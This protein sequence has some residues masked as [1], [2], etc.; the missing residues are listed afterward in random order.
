MAYLKRL[1]LKI[2]AIIAAFQGVGWLFKFDHIVQDWAASDPLLTLL[3]LVSFGVVDYI[4]WDSDRTRKLLD[5]QKKLQGAAR[6]RQ[7]RK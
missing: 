2:I 3:L 4:F 6:R 5:Y 7:K 1:L